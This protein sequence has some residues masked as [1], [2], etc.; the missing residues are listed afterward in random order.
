M[1]GDVVVGTDRRDR[2]ATRTLEQRTEDRVRWMDDSRND[3]ADGR[4]TTVSVSQPPSGGGVFGVARAL[5]DATHGPTLTKVLVFALLREFKP[6]EPFLVATYVNHGFA[7]SHITSQIFPAWAYARVPSLVLM[8]CSA[9]HFGCKATVLSGTAAACFTV[10][11]TLFVTHGTNAYDCLLIASQATAAFSQASHQAFLGLTFATLPPR[12]HPAAA[13]GVKA[14]ALLATAG[15]SLCGQ[16]L[17]GRGYQKSVFVTTLA[18]QLV[19]GFVATLFTEREGEGEGA[20]AS[21]GE[22]N[23]NAE[24]LSSSSDVQQPLGFEKSGHGNKNNPTQR[25][26]ATQAVTRALK[27]QRVFFWC[28][29]SLSCAPTHAFVAGN[30]QLLFVGAKHEDE[31]ETPLGNDVSSLANNNGNGFFLAAMQIAAFAATLAVGGVAYP[32]TD[33]KKQTGPHRVRDETKRNT[34][35]NEVSLVPSMAVMAL[36]L[37]AA[38]FGWRRERGYADSISRCA[39]V[40]FVCVFESTSSVCAACL[41]AE[42]KQLAVAGASSLPETANFDEEFVLDHTADE[43][44]GDSQLST[45]DNADDDDPPRRAAETRAPNSQPP[46]SS[47][48]TWLFALLSLAGYCVE[49]M[50]EAVTEVARLTIQKRFQLRSAGL[51]VFTGVVFG[52]RRACVSRSAQLSRA[53]EEECEGDDLDGDELT[54]P[55]LRGRPEHD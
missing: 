41:G 30:W 3:D 18:A 16:V 15:S 5:S 40:V 33:R 1:R 8:A 2:D 42:A 31:D 54:D 6:S 12:Y 46:L 43:T 37:F 51:L 50:T 17:W 48:L 29:W 25:W 39:V 9:K 55:L 49:V 28:L 45:A 22:N 47:R 14:V 4:S 11:V 44:R 32:G 13:H 23:C 34:L 27:N 26:S 24:S 19:S 36:A 21:N 38:G 53:A 35:P 20:A 7:A 52:T 10:A